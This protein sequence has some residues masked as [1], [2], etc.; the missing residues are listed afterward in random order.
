MW[1]PL[2]NPVLR[3]HV[4]SSTHVYMCVVGY[5]V[6]FLLN[7]CHV[8]YDKSTASINELHIKA[9]MLG[10]FLFFFWR[11]EWGGGRLTHWSFFFFF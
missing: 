5:S 2:C 9:E 11:G 1:E 4:A 8:S 10:V 6:M 3:M 7:V